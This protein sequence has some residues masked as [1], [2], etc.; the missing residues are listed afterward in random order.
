LISIVEATIESIEQ[1][2]MKTVGLLGTAITMNSSVYE[3]NL[4]KRGIMTLVP[5]EEDKQF[6]DEVIRKELVPG[7]IKAESRRSFVR[8]IDGMAS[9]GA[10]GV[11][12]GAQKSRCSSASVTVKSNFLTLP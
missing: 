5:S 2:R 8:I 3:E 6:V 1:Q 7:V 4:E 10:E 9:L 11:I 12:L